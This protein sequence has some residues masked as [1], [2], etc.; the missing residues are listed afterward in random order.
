MKHLLCFVFV[1]QQP[2]DQQE[3]KD[4]TAEVP[5]HGFKPCYST[6]AFRLA[7]HLQWWMSLQTY[8]YANI[9]MLKQICSFSISRFHTYARV[10]HVEQV[11]WL[12]HCTI[13]YISMCISMFVQGSD[14]QISFWQ[15]QRLKKVKHSLLG[16]FFD[17]RS[18]GS[19]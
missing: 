6:L 15:D 16:F 5:C 13:V 1:V 10:T 4:F 9:H 17:R 7:K 8:P 3:F 11:L 12:P 19:A 18:Q 2:L 14:Q